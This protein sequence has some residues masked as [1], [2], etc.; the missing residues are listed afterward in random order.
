[1][2][3]ELPGLYPR[4]SLFLIVGIASSYLCTR[5]TGAS[6]KFLY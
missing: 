1:M 2:N 5:L 6:A 4:S 3:I